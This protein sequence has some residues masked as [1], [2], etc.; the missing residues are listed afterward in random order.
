M[1]SRARSIPDSW[2]ASSTRSARPRSPRRCSRWPRSAARDIAARPDPWE[3]LTGWRHGVSAAIR[4]E[5]DVSGTGRIELHVTPLAGH[6]RW[7]LALA[8][9]EAPRIVE[10]ADEQ[11]S[12]HVRVTIDGRVFN[13]ASATA[14]ST[15]Y[16]ACGGEAWAISEVSQRGVGGGVESQDGAVR[17][18]MPGTVIAVSVGFRRRGHARARRWRSSRR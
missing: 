15:N 9:A 13:V 1:S 12:H 18:P 4:R 16:L 17:S 2:N 3:Q 7:S 11:D 5:L 6:R 10:L 8:D 14:G